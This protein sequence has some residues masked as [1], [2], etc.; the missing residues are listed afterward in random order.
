VKLNLKDFEKYIFPF[1]RIFSKYR[2]IKSVDQIKIFI[3]EQSAQVSQMTLYGYLKT[4]MGAKHV[5]MFEDKEFLNSINIAK[6]HIYAASL[7]DCTFFCFSFLHKEK[8]FLKTDQANKVFFEILNTEK[9][10]GMDLD[11][12][13]NATKEFNSRYENINWLTYYSS[14]PFEY[15]SNALYKWAPIADELKKL[16]KEIVLNSMILKWNNIQ[17]DFKKLVT[18]FEIK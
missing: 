10:N 4:R 17:K 13:Q 3:Q 18:N 9:A 6:W 2:Q 11:A 15:S 5:I 16:D 8:N 12:Y 1:K 7:I 14:N